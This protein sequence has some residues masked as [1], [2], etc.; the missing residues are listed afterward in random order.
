[1]T[2]SLQTKEELAMIEPRDA[3]CRL[4]E[5]AGLSR[6][7]RLQLQGRG[8]AVIVIAT[9]LAKVARKVLR[10]GKELLAQAPET[11]VLP[12]QRLRRSRTYEVRLPA[13]RD[14]LV[15]LGI[16]TGTGGIA[17]APPEAATSRAC[18]RRAYLRGLFLAAGSVSD[19]AGSLHLE[20]TL[21]H[22]GAAD[23]V[24]QLL[25]AEA[26]RIRMGARKQHMLLYL[27]EGEQIARFLTL[28]GAH[29]AVLRFE[30]AR[31]YRDVKGHVNRLV[32][33]ET[34][35][36]DKAV[37]A[38]LRQVED[39]RLLAATIG[40]NNLSPPLREVAELR[41]RYPEASLTDLGQRCRPPVSKSGVNH[42]LRRLRLLAQEMQ[43][44][45]K[46]EFNHE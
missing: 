8:R 5:L 4:A 38:G 41:M 20:M 24:S 44:K 18:C 6:G 39:I 2:F 13:S 22:T 26:V 42:R 28:V 9:E 15:M 1:M 35:N 36:L 30:N 23:A 21:R 25:F 10:L 43:S 31:A 17:M 45:G 32:N 40:L 16:L 27:K 37:Q 19:P 14:E 12:P 34:A 29:A 46:R 11:R 7:G 3:C 33:A